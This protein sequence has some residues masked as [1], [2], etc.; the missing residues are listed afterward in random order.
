MSLR[1]DEALALFSIP[2]LGW[3]FMVYGFLGVLGF[4]FLVFCL[5]LFWVCGVSVGGLSKCL[6][7][8]DMTLLITY[9]LSLR[10]AQVRFRFGLS[11][12]R[13]PFKGSI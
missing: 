11:N 1:S 6:L 10:T 12:S 5:F 8:A 3:D 13:I 9:L 2:Y 4:A 7:M